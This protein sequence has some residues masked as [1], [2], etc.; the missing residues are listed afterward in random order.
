MEKFV[1]V[2]LLFLMVATFFCTKISQAESNEKITPRAWG[3]EVVQIQNSGIPT[4][5]SDIRYSPQKDV[6]IVRYVFDIKGDE[7]VD[8]T[9]VVLHKKDFR[10]IEKVSLKQ[11]PYTTDSEVL[12]ASNAGLSRVVQIRTASLEPGKYVFRVI[13]AIEKEKTSI[14]RGIDVTKNAD[15]TITIG[16][17]WFGF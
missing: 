5:L 1:K 8:E 15:G 2:L 11:Q 10:F 13:L 3:V 6:S 9:I 17:E 4:H 16:S 7:D 12:A 14:R